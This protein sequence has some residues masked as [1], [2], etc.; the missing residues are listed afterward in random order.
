MLDEKL[1][2][3]VKEKIEFEEGKKYKMYICPAGHRTIGIGH[4]LDAVPI[5]EHAVDVIFRDDL[6]RVEREIDKHFSWWRTHP[7]A[8]QIFMLDFVFNVGI[9]T[10][11]DFKNTMGLIR[12]KRYREASHSLMKSRYARQVR[13]RAKRNASLILSAEEKK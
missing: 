8:I 1:Y 5:S 11:L 12:K 10:A 6:A 13:N 9:G 7:E 3:K 4:N 2:A